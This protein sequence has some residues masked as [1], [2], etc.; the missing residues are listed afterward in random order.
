MNTAS[1]QKKI[2]SPVAEFA[3]SVTANHIAYTPKYILLDGAPVYISDLHGFPYSFQ[4]PAGKHQISFRFADKKITLNDLT[5]AANTK[6]WLGFNNDSIRL[7]SKKLIVID[8]LPIAQPN[9]AEKNLLYGSLLLCNQFGYD[10]LQVLS[11]IE[12]VFKSNRQAY[13]QPA[14]LN[15]DGDYF[16]VFGPVTGT[17]SALVKLN[18]QEFNLKL[19]TDYAHY[20]DANK[21]EFAS[22]TR[23]A[24]KGVI[25]GFVEE[26]MNDTYLASMQV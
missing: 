22:K 15:I 18:T 19:S 4:V 5:F 6:T 8:S 1:S 3:I 20:Y 10:S 12:T 17:S 14:T 26:Q 24:V 2:Q 13:H 7:N 23:G 11:G 9:D 21:K 25:F 16:Y